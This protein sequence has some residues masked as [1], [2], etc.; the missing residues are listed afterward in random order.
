[1]IATVF[2]REITDVDEGIRTLKDACS[3]VGLALPLRYDDPEA[4]LQVDERYYP[5]RSEVD[6]SIVDRAIERNDLLVSGGSDVHN[7][8][9]GQAG[10][11]ESQCEEFSTR[12]HP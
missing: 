10:L 5:Y 6:T 3:A 1:M 4:A 9:L 11:S 8:R 7:K 12:L 2:S